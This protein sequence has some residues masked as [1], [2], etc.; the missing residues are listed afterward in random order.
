M[1][2]ILI[3]DDGDMNRDIL[4]K[5]LKKERI[6]TVEAVDG[7]E[8]IKALSEHDIDLIVL[9]IMMPQVDGFGVINHVREILNSALPIIIL[10]SLGDKETINKATDSGADGYFVKPINIKMIL[11]KIKALL[12][13]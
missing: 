5:V 13:E 4:S 1:K 9:D 12:D 7:V 11:E 2:K 8:A 6:E 10:S 3:V